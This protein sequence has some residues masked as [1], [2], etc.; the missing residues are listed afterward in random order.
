MNADENFSMTAATESADTASQVV[1]AKKIDRSK[2]SKSRKKIDQ[3]QAE[4]DPAI[5]FNIHV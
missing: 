4:Q 5:L 2:S 1:R 3:V